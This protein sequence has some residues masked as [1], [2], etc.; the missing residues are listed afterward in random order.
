[1]KHLFFWILTLS[2]FFTGQVQ[3]DCPLFAAASATSD[4]NSDNNVTTL[5][6]Q[7]AQARTP[8]DSQNPFS[9]QATQ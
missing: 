4:P 5:T 6:T 7:V 1:M 8:R 9:N 2:L 3:A